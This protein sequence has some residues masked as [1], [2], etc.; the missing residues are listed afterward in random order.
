MSWGWE[1]EVG[2]EVDY[3]KV[4][5]KLKLNMNVV[6]PDSFRAYNHKTYQVLINHFNL[7]NFNFLLGT[8]PAKQMIK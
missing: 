1:L 4:L 5:Q 7:S 3:V 8:L 2:I 6:R